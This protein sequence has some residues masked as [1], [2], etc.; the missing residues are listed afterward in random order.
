MENLC[1]ARR[2]RVLIVFIACSMSAFAA[3][4]PLPQPVATLALASMHPSS[5]E[6][7]A[8]VSVAFL[9]E[10]SIAVGLCHWDCA[11]KE[12]SLS[13]V[14]WEG[15]TLRAVAQTP[16]FDYGASVHP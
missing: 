4:P 8:W 11:N 9:S 14:R 5:Q 2:L 13:L 7:S 12:C 15:G 3:D 1:E 10:T 6:E 16:R